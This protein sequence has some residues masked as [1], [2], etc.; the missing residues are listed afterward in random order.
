V[1][2]KCRSYGFLCPSLAAFNFKQICLCVEKLHRAGIVHRD[3][4]PE[5][6]F[7]RGDKVI[8]IDFGSSDDLTQPELRKM[9]IDDDPK[10]LTHV[11]FVGTS[12]Y[13]AP[14]CVRNKPVGFEADIWS[15]GCI[16]Y[17]FIAGMC[18]FR[19]ASDY[20]IFRRSTEAKVNLDLLPCDES[21]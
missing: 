3:L 17:Q 4:K 19:G 10:R 5:N 18:P 8:L 15:L 6:M 11:N 16:L 9:K 13:M 20:L 21:R 12:Q 1:W 14:E 7:F 2:T